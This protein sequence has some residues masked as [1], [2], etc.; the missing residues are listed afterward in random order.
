[1]NPPYQKNLHLKIL[2]EAQASLCIDILDE[3]ENFVECI[4]WNGYRIS[5]NEKSAFAE[6]IW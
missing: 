1:M 5:F 6:G 4:I 2:E 3:N